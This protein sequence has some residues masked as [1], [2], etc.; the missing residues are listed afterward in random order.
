[1]WAVPE[2]RQ[3]GIIPVLATRKTAPEGIRVKAVLLCEYPSEFVLK[4]ESLSNLR[5]LFIASH[6]LPSSELMVTH[7]PV[8]SPWITAASL[9]PSGDGERGFLKR[10]RAPTSRPDTRDA[11]EIPESLSLNQCLSTRGSFV[12]GNVWGHFWCLQFGGSG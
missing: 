8:T 4:G 5:M 2:M 3:V 9:E 1:M 6:L 12:P 10:G 11:A 7:S